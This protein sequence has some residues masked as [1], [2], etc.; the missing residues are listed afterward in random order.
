VNGNLI[1][2]MGQSMCLGE[3][4]PTWTAIDDTSRAYGVMPQGGAA[5]LTLAEPNLPVL[6]GV[7][8]EEQAP[9]RPRGAD[10]ASAAST[11][12][13]GKTVHSLLIQY[14]RLQPL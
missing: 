14:C 2:H 5:V 10:K 6:F 3:S 11:P 4:N 12:S 8:G 9:S 1:F 13:R 7:T